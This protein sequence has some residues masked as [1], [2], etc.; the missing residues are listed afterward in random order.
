MECYFTSYPLGA[1]NGAFLIMNLV[2]GLCRRVLYLTSSPGD[3]IKRPI[4]SSVSCGS[5]DDTSVGTSTV[6]M[7]NGQKRYT[8][9]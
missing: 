9:I 4:Q 8:E 7:T 6:G 2:G 5:T 3:S 1:Y